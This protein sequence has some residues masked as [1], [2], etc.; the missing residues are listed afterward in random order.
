[1]DLKTLLTPIA[2][3]MRGVDAVIRARLSSEV[4]LI[5]EIGGYIVTAGGKRLRPALVLLAACAL[6]S[7]DESS[8]R[9]LAAVVEF[10]H[11]A[12][13]LHDDVVD[14]SDLRRGR[15]TANAVWGNAG[16]VLSGDFLY[17]RSFQMM[18]EVGKP[19]VMRVMADATNAIAE[20]E[21]LQLMNQGNPD[22]DEARYVRVIELK[23]AVLF[24]AACELGAIAAD[25]SPDLQKRL[26]DYGHALGIAFQ[27][28]DDVLD[29]TGDPAV[30]G[31]AVGNDL[32]EGKPTLPLIHAMRTGSDEDAALIRSAIREGKVDELERILAIVERTEAIPYTRA[33]AERHADEARQ[34]IRDLPASA[35]RETL[36]ELTRFATDRSS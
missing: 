2:D 20:G 35:W 3:D 11:T 27:M 4:A 18:V 7:K 12:T 23:T 36:M 26:R 5:N 8:R 19:A 14:H 6:G 29:Y 17:S 24:A 10:I 32:S 16:A 15:K 34:A 21:V 25:A 9:Q 28:I 13:L 1:M 22:V 30:S 33:L 31:K